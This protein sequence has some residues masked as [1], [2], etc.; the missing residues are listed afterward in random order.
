MDKGAAT[1]ETASPIH[2]VKL[3]APTLLFANV[4]Q[5]QVRGGFEAAY[6]DVMQMLNGDTDKRFKTLVSE[7][8]VTP[9]K[10]NSRFGVLVSVMYKQLSGERFNEDT[11]KIAR[12]LGKPFCRLSQQF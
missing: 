7:C 5:Q 1:A 11:L 4:K 2:H 9:R 12:I 10:L 3:I 8:D 6:A